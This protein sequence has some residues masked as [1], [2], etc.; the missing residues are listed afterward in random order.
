MLAAVRYRGRD[1]RRRRWFVPLLPLLL[2]LIPIL[3]I[4]CVYFRISPLG[5]LRGLG[6]VVWALPGAV[7][8]LDDGETAFSIHLR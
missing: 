3:L 8:D 2:L 1:G 4:A 6:R 7:F 5:G